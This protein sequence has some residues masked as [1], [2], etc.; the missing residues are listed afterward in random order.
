MLARVL[1][2]PCGRPCL[3][4]DIFPLHL[5]TTVVATTTTTTTTTSAAAAAAFLVTS[6]ADPNNGL[7]LVMALVN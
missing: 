4:T 6:D 5:A 7:C 3:Y 2:P 1:L